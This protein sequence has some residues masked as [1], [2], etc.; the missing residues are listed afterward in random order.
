MIRGIEYAHALCPCP[1][2]RDWGGSRLRKREVER[3]GLPLPCK[4]RREV[5]GI[6]R[7]GLVIGVGE[8]DV[9]EIC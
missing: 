8:A 4:T 5:D 9:G 3:N 6:G 2:G 1:D 7:N